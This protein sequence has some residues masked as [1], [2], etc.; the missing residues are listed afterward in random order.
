MRLV[1]DLSGP[2][3]SPAG[4]VLAIGAFDGLHR[5]HQALLAA[6]R[7]SA[8]RRGLPSGA[9]LF[10][11]LPRRYFARE[12][13]L[14]LMP[15]AQRLAGLIDAGLDHC[16][17]LRFN[18]ALAAMSPEA[19][20]TSALQHRLGAREVWVGE[21]FR[22]GHAR[23]GDVERLRELG[24]RHGF[25][26]RVLDTVAAEAERISSSR[27]RAALL[28]GDFATAAEQL[29][30]PYRYRRRVTRGQQLGR[31]LGYPTAN[32]RWLSPLMYGIY[33]VR[34]SGA[35][36]HRHP[37][38]A[39]IGTRPTVN[40]REPLLEVH[41]FDWSGDLYG[42]CLTVEFVARQRDELK[43]DSLDALVRQMDRDAAEA[44]AILAVQ[45]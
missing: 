32:L 42:Q 40:G 14:R 2:C 10:E 28:R 8:A 23:A 27:L 1:R 11:P 22:F 38:V 29:G 41:L 13:F 16:L 18:A 7:A 24:D 4:S 39:S 34:V 33:A 25:E 17:L 19:F 5:G 31:Q 21:D 44:R 35:G 36:L 37:A 30:A 3:L 26:V 45:P 9:V 43:F 6:V 12:P 15:P 20:V